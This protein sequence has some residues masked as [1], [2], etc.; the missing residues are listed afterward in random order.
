MLG[1]FLRNSSSRLIKQNLSVTYHINQRHYQGRHINYYDILGVRR[2]SDMK[3]VKVAYFKMAKK[4][5]PD[6]NRTL[7]AKQM[8]ELIAEAY[9]VLSDEKKR[10]EYD[11]TG[12]VSDRHG[13]RSA[14]GPG[15]QSTDSSYTAEQMY[16]KIFNTK[17]S[18]SHQGMAYQDYA[19]N[20]TG[21]L[22]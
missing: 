9:D 15:R 20:T 4:F 10:N 3:E 18:S 19:T 12:C 5:H 22:V 6:T 21:T 7:D 11:E 16:S 8:F 2:H 1:L 13:G 14:H 17:E